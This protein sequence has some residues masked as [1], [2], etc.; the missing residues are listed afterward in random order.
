LLKLNGT[1]KN[2]LKTERTALNILQ[3]MSGIATETN[4]LVKKIKHKSLLCSTRK[5]QWGLL[6][7]KAVMLGGGGTH[8][9]GLHDFILVKDNHLAATD[10]IN[11][12][13]LSKKFWEI[14]VD[15]TKQA[16]VFARYN[17]DAIMLDNFKP[18]TIK[19]TI[20]KLSPQIIFE[21]SG[22]ITESNLFEYAKTGV[23][24]ISMGSLTHSTKSL[25]I[26]LQVD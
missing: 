3:R 2:I 1:I 23:D 7:K 12:Q 26:N 25:N 6:D 15:S 18:Q 9:L 4:K 24:V 21:A 19:R 13:K 22:G 20:K 8:R 11:W 14:E 17:P 5:T 16:L 10:K